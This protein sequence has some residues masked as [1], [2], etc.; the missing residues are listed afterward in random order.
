MVNEVL[1]NKK[2]KENIK[3]D[4]GKGKKKIWE[5]ARKNKGYF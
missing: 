2:L 4:V 1:S 5:N 3:E